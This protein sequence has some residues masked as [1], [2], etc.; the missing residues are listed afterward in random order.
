MKLASA[1]GNSVVLA[2]LL[3]SREILASFECECDFSTGYFCSSHDD[4]ALV[5]SAID[6]V[7][8]EHLNGNRAIAG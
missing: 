8:R 2:A 6:E 3:R 7:R 1:P 5:E 4:L